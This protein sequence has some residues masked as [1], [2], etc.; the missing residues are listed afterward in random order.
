MPTSHNTPAPN[1]LQV[2]PELDTGGAERTTVDVAK[3]VLGAGGKALVATRGGRLQ[4][5]IEEAGGTV[6]NMPV[7]SKNPVTIFL[8]IFR[9]RRIIKHEAID[10]V[11]VRSRAPAWSALAAAR[12]TGTRFVTTYHGTYTAKSAL[13]RFY[14]SGMARGDEVIANSAFIADRIRAEHAGLSPSLT[15]IHRGTDMSLFDPAAVSEDRKQALRKDW[16]ISAPDETIILL[17]GR[18]TAWKGQ[19]VLVEAAGLLKDKGCEDFTIVLAGDAQGRDNYEKDLWDLIRSLD[20]ATRVRMP[21]HCADV[22]AA[23]ALSTLVVSASTEP[24]AFGRVAVEAQAMG[25]PIIASEHGGSLET[26]MVDDGAMTGWRVEP[27]DPEALA[28]AIAEALKMSA[29]KRSEIGARGR[30]NAQANF[31]VEA[32]CDSTL[33]VYDRVLAKLH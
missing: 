30:A 13:K 1:V 22:P 28:E 32:M 21:G 9:L 18:L 11:H 8:N 5:E 6:I 7:H 23:C 33:E 15:V 10:V 19:R 17:P 31:S 25:R 16:S 27:D 14:N 3:A 20:L 24:E 12:L 26:V 2:I 29:A 4:T